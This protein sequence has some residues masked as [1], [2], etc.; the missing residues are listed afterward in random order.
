MFFNRGKRKLPYFFLSMVTYT[1]QYMY[2]LHSVWL[3]WVLSFVVYCYIYFCVR[4]YNVVQASGAANKVG[5]QRPHQ[6]GIRWGKKTKE[7]LPVPNV[8]YVCYLLWPPYLFLQEHTVTWSVCLIISCALK[9]QSWWICTSECILD[10]H[11]TRMFPFLYP[12]SRER[13]LWIWTAWTWNSGVQKR[14]RT[15]IDGHTLNQCDQI[16]SKGVTY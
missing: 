15:C 4:W 11:M 1:Y 3:L 2:I 12:G 9:T 14:H 10:G 5:S 13:A 7:L 8:S 6:G 16:F